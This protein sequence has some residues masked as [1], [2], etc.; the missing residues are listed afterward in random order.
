ML[1]HVFLIEDDEDDQLFFVEALRELNNDFYCTVADNG[2]R[3]LEMLN[4]SANLPDIIFLDINM[5]E[6]NGFECLKEL[7]KS[8]R[9]KKI[10]VVILSTSVSVEDMIPDN[11]ASMFFS[12]PNS[13]KKL[14]ALLKNILD[15]IFLSE[16]FGKIK[17][18]C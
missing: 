11:G 17:Q 1:K 14:S 16:P 9:F 13:C 8:P 18:Q 12:K 5:P 3:A 7:K 2:R 15:I 6:L 4:A 10:P